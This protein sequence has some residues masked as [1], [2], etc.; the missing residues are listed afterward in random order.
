[1][2][3]LTLL[4]AMVAFAAVPAPAAAASKST[5]PLPVTSASR[6]LALGD[7]VSFG[8]QDGTNI[9]PFQLNRIVGYPEVLAQ[10][11]H[12]NLANA[13]CPGETSSSFINTSAPDLGCEPYRAD[14]PLHV[15]YAGS[16]LSYALSY[17]KS[18]KNVRLV[19]LEMGLVDLSLCQQHSSD[20]CSS[21][22]ELAPMDRT[23][24]ANVKTIL[25]ALRNKAHYTGQLAVVNYY[26][27]NYGSS[28]EN[29]LT[30]NIDDVLDAASLGYHVKFV[31][32]YT[33]FATASARDDEDPCS[34]GLIDPIGPGVCGYHPTPAGQTVIADAIRHA[35]T[36]GKPA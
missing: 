36:V 7:S 16:Q 30:L 20:G 24:G 1:M 32:A 29:G 27:T 17:L 23:L 22:A 4:C 5:K 9:T 31:N 21:A 34:A 35:I 15:H 19:S 26:S 28:L 8:Y 18:H 10:Q 2:A 14:Y 13:S 33:A 6:Y 12:L 25:S 3:A 11:L